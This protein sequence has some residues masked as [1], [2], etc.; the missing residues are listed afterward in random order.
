MTSVG[1]PLEGADVLVDVQNI[2]VRCRCGDERVVDEHDL[3][4]HIY[5]CPSCGTAREIE[6]ADDLRIVDVVVPG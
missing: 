2:S 4:G 3:A 5:V 1:T 6:E